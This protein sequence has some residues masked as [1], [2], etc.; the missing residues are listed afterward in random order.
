MKSILLR[1]LGLDT[2]LEAYATEVLTRPGLT[3]NARVHLLR[4]HLGLSANKQGRP[5]LGLPTHERQE[6]A[7]AYH[8]ERYAKLKSEGRCVT[9]AEPNPNAPNHT[10][11][12]NC[13]KKK[14]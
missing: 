10:R 7:K 9:C 8:R 1:L 5:S 6:R 12:D 11:C 4:A 13:Q 3:P 2:D 14:A